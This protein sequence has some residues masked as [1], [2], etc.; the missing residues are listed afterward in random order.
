M[1]YTNRHRTKKRKLTSISQDARETLWSK[2]S[3]YDS[4]KKIPNHIVSGHVFKSYKNEIISAILVKRVPMYKKLPHTLY[5]VTVNYQYLITKHKG[6]KLIS[7]CKQIRV[8]T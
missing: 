8:L 4:K 1:F 3:G 7:Q 5:E 2:G 6:Y